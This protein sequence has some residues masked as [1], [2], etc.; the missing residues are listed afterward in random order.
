MR[1]VTVAGPPSV[2]KTSLFLKVAARLREAGMAANVRLVEHDAPELGM[3]H[4]LA[5]ADA[6]IPPGE[7]VA[8]LLADLPDCDAAT[9]ARVIAAYDADADVVVP[10]AA[11]RFGHPVVFGPRAR[12]RI[13]P[14]DSH[15]PSEAI[16]GLS[17]ARKAM[18]SATDIAGA[19]AFFRG[20]S[21]RPKTLNL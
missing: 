13:G 16:G 9:V 3:N 7:P 2:G 17:K 5:L 19:V 12:A 1:L 6:T 14:G 20:S 18:F 4:S 8:V 11:G 15:Q 21:G 10:Q